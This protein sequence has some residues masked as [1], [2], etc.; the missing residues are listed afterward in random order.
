MVLVAVQERFFISSAFLAEAGVKQG[1]NLSPLLFGLFIDQIENFFTERCGVDGIRIADNICR[2]ILYA[3]DL[4]LLSESPSGLQR[5]LHYLEEFCLAF[6]M[7]V[8]VKKSEVV[9]FNS[10]FL[11]DNTQHKWQFQGKDLPNKE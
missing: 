10:N 2:V 8:N 11:D 7:E 1:D 6:K 3:D 9:V 4:A 5:S